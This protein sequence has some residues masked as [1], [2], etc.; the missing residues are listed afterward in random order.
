MRSLILQ[1]SKPK[2]IRKNLNLL[3]NSPEFNKYVEG[4]ERDS[5]SFWSSP[6]PNNSFKRYRLGSAMLPPFSSPPDE[7]IHNFLNN[8]NQ[9]KIKSVKIETDY[10]NSIKISLEENDDLIFTLED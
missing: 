7:K 8:N 5:K 1:H 9:N 3:P 6:S 10:A 4:L 2:Q